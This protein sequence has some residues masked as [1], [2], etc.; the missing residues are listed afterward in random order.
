MRILFFGPNGSG[1]GTQSAFL[2]KKYH[3]AHIES[4]GI[5]RTNIKGG[6]DLG[7]QA[8]AYINKGQLVPDSITIPMIIDRL[9]QDDC[10]KGWILDGFPRNPAQGSALVEALDAANTPLDVVI[11]IE[12]SRE[13]S[14]ARLMGRR[15]CPNGHPNNTAIPAIAPKADDD[16]LLCWKCDAEVSVRADDVDEEAIDQRHDIYYDQ[17]AG[18]LAS[19]A[20]LEKWAADVDDVR[21]IHIDGDGDI[22]SIRE[23]VLSAVAE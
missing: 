10:A 7:K 1:K 12:L 22:A 19:V 5:F 2:V 13:I 14:K 6:T 17:T 16:Q 11:V 21:V 8:L 18:T 4:G 9:A 3:L 15:S 20:V 23:A